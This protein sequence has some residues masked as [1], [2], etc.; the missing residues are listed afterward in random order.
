MD[1]H[2]GEEGDGCGNCRSPDVMKE[3]LRSLSGMENG[4]GAC[5]VHGTE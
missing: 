5:E 2:D 4:V 3:M 1:N